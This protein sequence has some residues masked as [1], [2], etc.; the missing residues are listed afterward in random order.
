MQRLF[1]E[2]K[3]FTNYMISKGITDLVPYRDYKVNKVNV[4]VKDKFEERTKV[5][6]VADEAIHYK[7]AAEQCKGI[8]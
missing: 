2:G 8:A 4:K 5:I 3:W 7:E 1:L 6:V